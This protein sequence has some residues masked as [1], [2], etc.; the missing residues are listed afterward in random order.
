MLCVLSCFSHVRLFL[1]LWIEGHQ[2]PLSMGFFRQEYW[3]GLPSPPAGDLPDP[4]I[5]TM[6]PALQVDSLPLNH[7]GSP[8]LNLTLSLFKVESN[9]PSL[10]IDSSV[11]FFRIHIF[12]L[13]YNICFSLSD[14]LHYVWQSLDP[15]TSLQK[16]QFRSFLWLSSI[17]LYICTMSSLSVH[18]L[19]GIKVASMSWLL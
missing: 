6:S 19:M 5:K 17:P 14:L 18:L 8:W 3:S 2:A 10:Q 1:T 7:W 16:T 9:N 15:S 13:I 4:G 11:P 12:L